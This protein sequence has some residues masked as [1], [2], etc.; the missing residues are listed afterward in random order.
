MMLGQ[1]VLYLVYP[2]ISFFSVKM[3]F[4]VRF[5]SF[6]ISPT[7]AFSGEVGDLLTLFLNFEL[8]TFSTLWY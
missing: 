5:Y 1:L 4:D 8:L 6:C 7:I 3:G 2:E